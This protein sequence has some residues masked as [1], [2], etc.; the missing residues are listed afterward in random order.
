MEEFQVGDTCKAS[1]VQKQLRE[2]ILLRGAMQ[3][4]LIPVPAKFRETPPAK[5]APFREPRVLT[6]S[7]RNVGSYQSNVEAVPVNHIHMLLFARNVVSYSLFSMKE[8]NVITRNKR[9]NISFTLS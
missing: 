2:V 7:S 8:Y 1:V 4:W 6:T 5:V 9:G 3:F